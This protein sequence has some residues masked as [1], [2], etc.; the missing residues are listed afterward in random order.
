MKF[1]TI[2]G[3]SGSIGTSA[4]AF[5]RRHRE[6]F[7]LKAVSFSK[8]WE[9]AVAIYREFTP[10]VVA[11]SD[12]AAARAFQSAI[13]GPCRVIAGPKASA[14]IASMSVD[15]VL[16]AIS[17]SVGF[18]S[19][20]AAVKAGN[21]V[22]LANKEALV[23][24]GTKLLALAKHHRAEV[25]PV[26]SEHSAI[27]QCVKLGRREELRRLVLTASGGPFRD[28]ARADIAQATAGAALKHP[29]WQMGPKNSL[30]SATLANKGLELIEACYF[31]DMPSSRV[32]VFVNPSSLLHSAAS[33]IDGSMIALLGHNDM[34]NAIGYALSYPDR[35]STGI[36]DLDLGQVGTLEF[37]RIDPERFPCLGLARQ[38][39]EAGPGATMMFNAANEIAGRMF[40][41]GRIGF[42]AISDIIAE[43][44]D[45]D[46][47]RFDVP[48]DDLMAADH[49][50]KTLATQIAEEVM[51][52][53]A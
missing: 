22:A 38:A 7:S 43:G 2:L 11:F 13:T 10:E 18:P 20:H 25:I 39:V 24:G 3:A 47:G 27:F 33:F 29:T 21:R 9:K 15:I 1:V 50:A 44:L 14:D 8:S 37:R 35:M 40:M 31:F 34:K 52:G 4:L 6:H 36:D 32:D 48:L 19:V 46:T 53:R 17:G 45:R 49:E 28:W 41:A 30:D 26:D 23:C 16:A 12:P 42:Y 5:L 51:V